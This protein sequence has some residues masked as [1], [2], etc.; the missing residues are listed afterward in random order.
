M[1]STKILFYFVSIFLMAS[2]RQSLADDVTNALGTVVTNEWE[3]VAT[4]EWG[5]VAC[6]VQISIALKEPVTEIKAGEPVDLV[7]RAKNVSTNDAFNVYE[8][9]NDL[10]FAIIA[11]SGRD[12]SPVPPKDA[13]SSSGAVIHVPAQQ[14]KE[15]EYNPNYKFDEIGTYTITAKIPIRNSCQAVSNPLSVTVVEESKN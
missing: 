4:N 3:A 9:D 7:I 10:S 8:D 6:N 13:V 2:V 1:K 14:T 5:A 11:P 12:V 15:F